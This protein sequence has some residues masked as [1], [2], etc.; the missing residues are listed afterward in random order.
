MRSPTPNGRAA[1]AVIAD[2][3]EILNAASRAMKPA[4]RRRG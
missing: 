1:T 4:P 2:P 3:T